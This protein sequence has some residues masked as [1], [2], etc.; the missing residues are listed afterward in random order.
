MDADADIQVW[1]EAVS[2]PPPSIVV[3][4]VKTDADTTLRY[5]VMVVK[6]GDKGKSMI[7][8]AGKAWAQANVPLPLAHVSVSQNPD[9]SC[10]IDLL[11]SITGRADLNYRFP[12]DSSKPSI[13]QKLPNEIFRFF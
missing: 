10:Y 13:N 6:Q 3:P 9:E 11:L 4:Y 5:K 12:C 7:S 8:Q 1:L 2:R